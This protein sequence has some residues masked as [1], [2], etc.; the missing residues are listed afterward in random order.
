M[1]R[2]LK[3]W[4][5]AKGMVPD[6]HL[7]QDKNKSK[8]GV[9]FFGTSTYSAEEA[10]D[11]L[12]DRNIALDALRLKAFP[13]NKGVEDFINAHDKI[14]VVEQNRDA[15]LR[16]LIMIELGIDANKLIPVLNYNG[17]PITAD[18]ISKQ[19]MNN[20]SPV[21]KLKKVI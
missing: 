8:N 17:M 9:I 3:K 5:T 13:F 15:Q 4:D 20:L 2:L 7:Y 18:N 12:K 10:M 11:I 6:S 16:S 21:P 1:D 19:V 14:F